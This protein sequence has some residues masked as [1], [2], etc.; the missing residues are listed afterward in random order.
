MITH[1][2]LFIHRMT[3]INN[4]RK[5]INFFIEDNTRI[6]GWLYLPMN[7]DVSYPAIIMT[8]GFSAVK[9]MSL[10]KYA[11]VFAEAGFAVLVYDHRNLGASGGEPRYE[12][13]PMQ[14]V[15]GYSSAISWLSNLEN[16][17]A[18][19]IGI[20]GSSYSGGHVLVVAAKDK[21]VKCVVSQ[22]PFIDGL[23]NAR[24]L[25]GESMISMASH[26]IE[27]D[28]QERH[29]GKQPGMI[30]VV[31]TRPFAPCV[32]P[33]ADAK[34][35]FTKG[36]KECAPDWKNEVT[37]QSV[38]MLYDYKPGQYIRDIDSIP[39]L[40]IIASEDQ[41][42][43]ADLARSAFKNAKEPKQLC[44]VAGAHFDVYDNNFNKTSVVARDWFI[45]YL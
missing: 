38:Q 11:E 44:E 21:R 9:E 18:E 37:L 24:R 35:W 1:G 29:A 45:K 40:M 6:Q 4:V 31:S 41:L 32:L 3:Y 10:D 28:K 27:K 43:P 12:I 2:T 30:P 26:L 7:D 13:D 39:L 33:T 14:Q 8:H 20:W 34:E 36:Q 15:D 16:I 5:D 22:T 23:E 19:S 25:V 42:A 17:N